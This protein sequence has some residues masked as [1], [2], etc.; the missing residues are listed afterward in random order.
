MLEVANLFWTMSEKSGFVA[1]G[2]ISIDT[3]SEDMPSLYNEKIRGGHNTEKWRIVEEY[4][5]V[6]GDRNTE[7]ILTKAAGTQVDSKYP[8]LDGGQLWKC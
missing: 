3:L 4:S 6:E 1:A 7:I 8:S 2:M 5:R